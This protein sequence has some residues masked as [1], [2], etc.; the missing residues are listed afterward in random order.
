[1]ASRVVP[2]SSLTMARS[3]RTIELINE[4]L[5]TFGRPT[6]AIAIGCSMLDVR[7]SIFEGAGRHRSMVSI[8]SEI[9][10]PWAEL[11]ERLCENP[12]DAKSIARS[13]CFPVSIL[14]MARTI[15]FCD[16]R[17]IRASS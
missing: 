2:G 6:I 15:G 9:P 1:M 5:P 17:S 14:F 4:D 12:S 8:N 11:I 13:S 16:L 10:R 3:L 7:R